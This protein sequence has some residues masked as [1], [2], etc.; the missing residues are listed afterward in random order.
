MANN[1]SST[2]TSKKGAN[3][4]RVKADKEQSSNTDASIPQ[5]GWKVDSSKELVTPVPLNR[6][7]SLTVK[8]KVM[9]NEKADR[10][11][12]VTAV[13]FV[14]MYHSATENGKRVPYEFSFPINCLE[15]VLKHFHILNEWWKNQDEQIDTSSDWLETFK[16][17]SKKRNIEGGRGVKLTLQ[18]KKMK[19]SKKD[20]EFVELSEEEEDADDVDEAEEEEDEEEEE[21]D[22]D[23]ESDRESER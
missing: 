19:R 15:K 4:K 8:E 20:P 1:Q 21:D 18:K 17:K 5:N 14:K 11:Y 2:S 22:A 6:D 3:A 23:S 10:E 7:Y 12:K 16:V 13:T 9:K